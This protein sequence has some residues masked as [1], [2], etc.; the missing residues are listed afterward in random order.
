MSLQAL[1]TQKPVLT[2]LTLKVLL[3]EMDNHMTLE[4]MT[5]IGMSP[6]KIC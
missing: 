2:H 6:L 4:N 3:R 5:M 1:L